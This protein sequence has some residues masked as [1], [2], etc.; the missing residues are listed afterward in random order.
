[1][2]LTLQNQHAVSNPP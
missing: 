2:R 1:M